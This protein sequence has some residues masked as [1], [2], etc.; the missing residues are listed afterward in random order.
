M[1]SKKTTRNPARARTPK[2]DRLSAKLGFEILVQ[3]IRELESAVKDAS[4]NSRKRISVITERCEKAEEERDRFRNALAGLNPEG[5]AE[6]V[7]ALDWIAN[8]PIGDAEA[9][10][11]AVLSDIVFRAREAIA[12]ARGEA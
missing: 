12:K 3:R 4:Y 8:E 9:T 2:V 1:E 11:R 7:A 6:A 10:H 5:V